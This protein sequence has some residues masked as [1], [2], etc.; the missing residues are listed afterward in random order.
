VSSVDPPAGARTVTG[1]AKVFGAH[2]LYN[3][4]PTVSFGQGIT[5]NSITHRDPGEIDVNITIT[6]QAPPAPP[7]PCSCSTPAPAQARS[8]VV[9]AG[10][11]QESV[12]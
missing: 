2:F 10:S 11:A 3:P 8:G 1:V 9:E 5:I 6:N 12:A 4:D 7:A